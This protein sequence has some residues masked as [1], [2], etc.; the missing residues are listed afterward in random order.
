MD[1]DNDD[2]RRLCE[3]SDKLL[4]DVEIN[5]ALVAIPFMHIIKAHPVLLQQYEPILSK[6]SG[7]KS[8]VL[9]NILRSARFTLEKFGLGL[10]IASNDV[11]YSAFG[12]TDVNLDVL[13]ISHYINADHHGISADFYF[14]NLPRKLSEAGY[15][16]GIVHIN[17]TSQGI[18]ELARFWPEDGISRYFLGRSCHPVHTH[19]CL[20][21]IADISKKLKDIAGSSP[22]DSFYACFCRFASAA[23]KSRSTLENMAIARNFRALLALVSAKLVVFTHEGQ[24]WER[25]FC[26]ELKRLSPGTLRMGYIHTGLF[27]T[28]HSLL[29]DMPDI[30][31]PDRVATTGDIALDQLREAAYYRIDKTSVLGSH[32]IDHLREIFS[33]KENICLVLPEGLIE[34]CALLFRFSLELARQYPD[35]VFIW[36]LHPVVTFAQIASKNHDL[37]QYPDNIVQSNNSYEE[38]LERSKWALYRGSTA[39]IPALAARVRP[40]YVQQKDEVNMDP[41]HRLKV[42]KQSVNDPVDLAPIFKNWGT[43]TDKD[44]KEYSV[45]REFC[46][47]FY[48]PFDMEKIT[49]LL[50]NNFN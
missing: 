15:R 28:Q 40:I 3:V 14:G 44:I 6:G 11:G 12:K 19:D 7:R 35:I 9:K 16:V 47:R 24:A 39:I 21:Q 46:R 50:P 33:P 32:K 17:H 2:Y 29:K 23:A 34:E 49:S 45:A 8:R 41:L 31:C 5:D 27:A 48:R 42:W 18:S 13:F 20:N 22:A 4:Q 43:D 37:R 10:G 36:R 25:L 1:I 26:A 38:D 30:Y